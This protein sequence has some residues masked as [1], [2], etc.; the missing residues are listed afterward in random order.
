MN[1]AATAYSLNGKRVW[2]AGH[3]GLVGSALVKRLAAENCELITVARGEVDL[4]RQK[5]V[6]DW[7]AET[8]PEAI[9]LAAATVG[10]IHANDSRPAEFLYDNMMIEANIVDAGWRVGV[11]KLLFL[12]STCI[13]P[14]FAPQPMAEGD[15]L[16][17]PLDPTNQWYALAKIAGIYLCQAYRRQHGCDFISAMPANLFGPGDFFEA[18]NSHVI[19]ALM[20]K[21]HKARQENAAE[22]EIWGSGEPYREFLY[23]EDAADALVFLMKTYS[24]AEHVNIGTGEE[25]KIIDMARLIA[26]IVGYRGAWK[27]DRGRHDGTPRKLSDNSLLKSLGWTPGT[28]LRDGLQATYDWF[29]DADAAGRIRA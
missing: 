29:R 3:G 23:S 1:D 11:E 26:D 8:R 16:T 24:G 18:E 5:E 14:K 4:R 22:V 7:L 20:G 21:I 15:L 19:P 10:G 27:F 12:G 25:I 13:Y 6:E 9:F 28:D 17:G 2:V